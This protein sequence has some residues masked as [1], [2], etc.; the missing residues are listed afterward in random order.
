MSL[1]PAAVDEETAESPGQS[2]QAQRQFFFLFFF[3]PPGSQD[4]QLTPCSAPTPPPLAPTTDAGPQTL[5]MR[6]I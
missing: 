1:Q 6:S 3:P 5:P 4:A 2:Q